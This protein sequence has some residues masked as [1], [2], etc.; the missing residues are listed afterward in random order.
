M[1]FVKPRFQTDPDESAEKLSVVARSQGCRTT[2]SVS[3]TMDSGEIGASKGL[4]GVMRVFNVKGWSRSLAATA[5][6]R[7]AYE[8]TEFYEARIELDGTTLG[9]DLLGLAC[10]RGDADKA[11]GASTS[12]NP[13]LHKALTITT[14]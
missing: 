10:W 6:L 7:C 3:W 13:Q 12:A 14:N 2:P 9:S 1:H 8:K 11:E 4:A 5:I